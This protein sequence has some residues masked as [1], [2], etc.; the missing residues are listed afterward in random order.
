VIAWLTNG[1]FDNQLADKYLYVVPGLILALSRAVAGTQAEVDEPASELA[2]HAGVLAPV[3]VPPA[4]APEP[5]TL[6]GV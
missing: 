4:L 1:V 6:V 2:P 3:D 5:Q